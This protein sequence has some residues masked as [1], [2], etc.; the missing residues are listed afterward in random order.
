MFK[1]IQQGLNNLFKTERKDGWYNPLTNLGTMGSRTNPTMYGRG[2]SLDHG[3]LRE[4]YRSNGIG[5][6]IV[7][8]VVENCKSTLQFDRNNII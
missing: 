3:I 2:I 7:N 1:I 8:L 4:I 5:K 6:R